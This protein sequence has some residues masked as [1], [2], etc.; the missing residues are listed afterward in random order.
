MEFSLLVLLMP[1]EE[2]GEP[3]HKA[4]GM[5]E[6]CSWQGK[7]A[8]GYNP[9]CKVLAWPQWLGETDGLSTRWLKDSD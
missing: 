5:E 3:G 8:H 1:Y 2:R 9:T 4:A 6:G 7:G